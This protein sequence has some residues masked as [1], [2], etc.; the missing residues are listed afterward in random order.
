VL[1]HVTAILKEMN[2]IP[3]RADPHY[4][5]NLTIGDAFA[6]SAFLDPRSF[7]QIK[8]SQF[9]DLRNEHQA[10]LRA[11]QDYP[12][13]VPQPLACV[14]REGWYYM[15]SNGIV[16]KPFPLGLLQRYSGPRTPQIQ[17]LLYYFESS[18]RRAQANQA[19]SHG[20]YFDVI[21]AYFAE[22]EYATIASHW[23]KYARQQNWQDLSQVPQHGDFVPNNL[24]CSRGR[25]VIFDWEDYGK[26]T[27]PGL[28]L[29]TL[30]I[31]VLGND[32]EQLRSFVH[33]EP[34]KHNYRFAT[35]AR[36]ATTRLGMEF[37][38]FRRQIPF[39]LLVFLYL[40][41]N[42]GEGVRER[43]GS[44]LTSLSS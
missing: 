40:K 19:Q 23:F 18:Q 24:A 29:A 32:L 27:L 3:A 28:D 6:I 9:I 5:I 1:K 16:H 31:S 33:T 42:Y 41:R 26:V 39:Y 8:A 38:E 44:L 2:L 21:E 34:Q 43:F 13:L 35:F 30:V 12:E 37:N 10:Y 14:E 4:N 20:E 7:M 25:L 22:T 36:D 11:W 15:I 17:D